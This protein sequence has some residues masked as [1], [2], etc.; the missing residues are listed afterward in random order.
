MLIVYYQ[1]I[2]IFLLVSFLK[3]QNLLNKQSC[4]RKVLYN[5]F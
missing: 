1:I 4:V 2:E 5:K 3:L